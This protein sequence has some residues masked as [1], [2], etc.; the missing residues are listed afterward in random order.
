M[1]RVTNNAIDAGNRY[2]VTSA[3]QQPV[4]QQNIVQHQ[5]EMRQFNQNINVNV[6]Q[7]RGYQMGPGQFPVQNQV[8]PAS[9]PPRMQQQPSPNSQSASNPDLKFVT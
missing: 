5:P 7:G 2:N 9:N 8:Q 3:Q 6:D 4:I 1:M